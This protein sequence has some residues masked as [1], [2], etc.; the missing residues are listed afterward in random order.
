M[1]LVPPGEMERREGRPSPDAL[2]AEVAR[3]RRG[4]FKIFLGPAPGVGKTYEMLGNARA[5]QAEGVDVVVGVV[6]THGRIETMARVDGLEILPPR[7][8]EYKGRVLEEMDL[9]AVLA[10]RPALVLVDELAHSNAPGS[11]HPKR[12]LDV[13]EIL[14]AGIDVYSTLNI[15]HLESLND[16]V[17]QITR[18]RVRET[19]PDGILD[20][21]DEIEIIDLTPEAL[22]QRLKDG[23]V[24]VKDQAHRALK[25]Y[26]SPGNLTALRE[27]A[28]RATAARV[29]EQM[30]QYMQRH[31]I[32]GPWAAGDR[33]VV[34][35]GPDP[36]SL[37]LVRYAKRLADRLRAKWTAL[38][39]EGTRHNA[40]SDTERDTVSDTLRL[41]ERLGGDAITVPGRRI[42]DDVLA[43]ARSNNCTH[44]IVG[45]SERSRWFE[46]LNG[47]VVHD[48]VRDAGTI[49]VHVMAGED[50]KP[51]SG[52]PSVRTQ[53]QRQ[54]IDLRA[55]VESAVMVAG[56]TALSKMID[57]VVTLPN[58]SLVYLTAVLFSAVRSGLFPSM[59]ASLLS[60]AAYNFFFLPPLY[61]FTIA[62]PANVLALVFFLVVALI[63]SNLTAQMQRQAKSVADRARST[64]EL[65]SFSRKIAGI[66][67][68][69]DLLWAVTYQIAAMLKCD[70]VLLL[71]EHG[72]LTVKSGYPPEDTLDA[73]DLAAA[74]WTW[75]H[76]RPAG[77]G[78]DT[79]PGGKRLFLPLQTERG[80]VGVIGIERDMPELLAPDE[81]RLLDALLDQGAVAIERVTLADEIDDARLQAETERL[82]NALLTSVSH[83][84]R[85]P[86]ATII[87]ALSALKSYGAAYDEPTRQDLLTGAQDE[88]ERLNRFVGNLLDMTRLESGA[89]NVTLEQID[90]ADTVDAV[91]RRA[92]PLLTD[93]HIAVDL[94]PN[95]PMP[96]A[97]AVL[98]EQ[99]LFNLIDNAAKYTPSGST[100][101]LYGG[102]EL[103][104]VF[105]AVRDEGAGIP[106]AKLE[107][108]F[109]KF[110]RLQEGDRVRA[111]TGLGLP[112]CRGFMQAMGG[113][114]VAANRSD[115]TGA[116]FTLTLPRYASGDKTP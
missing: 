79:L 4:R 55:Y 108:I 85:T 27:L 106:P 90:L 35:V 75:S 84:L 11:R 89:I 87:G 46:L 97:D 115:R 110:T 18:I 64:G 114:I 17:A 71:P 93:H 48:L 81:R 22:I 98:L 13:E 37:E 51:G 66:G 16:V 57:T 83:D 58:L 9:D 29:D 82:R 42:A 102:T 68:L 41:A 103:D 76:N 5:K 62:D 72:V 3:S 52:V 112:I 105:L 54:P 100:I 15:Q 34:C 74:Q 94:P 92:K 19:V 39:V 113:T 86:L 77:R 40:L 32:E 20:Q 45:K 6:E 88:A 60:V 53:R 7:R 38:Y 69:E 80:P 99:V 33:V 101:T 73:A 59:M 50:Q 111:G 95:L 67:A 47:S 63:V 21:A 8:V 78:A 14:A 23:K 107:A 65:Y 56:A 28:L 36:R 25:H 26:F 43:Y 1:N 109:D 91:K 49:S 30:L 24:Y 2:L 61:T 70:V 44:I 96:M 10:R 12:Y 116:I 104:R 31:A